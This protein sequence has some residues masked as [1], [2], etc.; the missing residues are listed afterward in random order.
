MF[1]VIGALWLIILSATTADQT[2]QKVF[3]VPVELVLAH[4]VVTDVNGRP[5][6]GLKGADFLLAD[7][8][9][10]QQISYFKPETEPFRVLIVLDVSGSTRR[11]IEL[12]KAAAKRFLRQLG[13]NDEI[14]L[15]AFGDR[16]QTPSGFTSDRKQLERAVDEIRGGPSNKTILYDA[17]SFAFRVAFKGI[18]GRKALV[19][20][21]DGFDTGS[22]ID[23]DVL[24]GYLAQTDCLIYSLVVD[25][26]A[27][28]RENMIRRRGLPG[29]SEFA[30]VLDSSCEENEGLVID[31]AG[32]LVQRHG[33]SANIW[34]LARNCDD[35]PLFIAA[36]VP[37]TNPHFDKSRL[38]VRIRSVRPSKDWPER[39]PLS[40]T[41]LE[42]FVI[43]D[44]KE[45]IE[46]RLGNCISLQS[47]VI[48]VG[49]GADPAQWQERIATFLK[50][51]FP[52]LLTALQLL[53]ENYRRA[54][55]NMEVIAT[56]TGGRA[57][58]LKTLKHVDEFYDLVARE[59]RQV[60]TLGFYPSALTPGFHLLEVRTQTPGLSVRARQ[61]Y[62]R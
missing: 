26:E 13:P 17:L 28:V 35:G 47:Q 46:K 52:D 24:S 19:L 42:T 38:L 27:D 58:H 22:G 49:K 37:R 36:S 7:N 3:K 30:L 10:P 50:Q 1:S 5:V 44:T 32:Y 45:G 41:G 9:V 53:P 12:I 51:R 33:N 55:H 34:L 4:A 62:H 16:I 61:S 39:V 43:T 40:K 18:E 6:T 48:V 20:L 11:K 57:Y 2:P 25:T 21:S 56:T 14:A 31:A 60:Y 59:L 54:R 15:M 29:A 8:G 23:V